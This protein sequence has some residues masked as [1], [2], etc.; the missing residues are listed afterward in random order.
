MK[1]ENEMKEEW[2]RMIMTREDDMVD[3]EDMQ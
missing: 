2:R 1:Y 3:K